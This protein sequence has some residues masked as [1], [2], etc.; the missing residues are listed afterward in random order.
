MVELEH[1]QGCMEWFTHA[2]NGWNALW[3]ASNKATAQLCSRFI[4]LE[5][6]PYQQALGQVQVQTAGHHWCKTDNAFLRCFLGTHY[7]GYIVTLLSF[8]LHYHTVLIYIATKLLWQW[9]SGLN[10]WKSPNCHTKDFFWPKGNTNQP[11]LVAL[12]QQFSDCGP[13]TSLSN[14]I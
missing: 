5:W 1:K 10:R 7:S 3:C 8:F 14:C 6:I 2:T 12:H 4:D 11:I 13:W 9:W